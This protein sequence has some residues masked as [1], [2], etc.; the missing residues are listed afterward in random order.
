MTEALT[1]HSMGLFQITNGVLPIPQVCIAIDCCMYLPRLGLLC[2]SHKHGGGGTALHVATSEMRRG[3][4]G[5][6]AM[7]EG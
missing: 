2:T 7:A 4:D 5:R 3:D 1:T 6:I